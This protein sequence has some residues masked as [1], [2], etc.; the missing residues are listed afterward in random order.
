VLNLESDF[1]ANRNNSEMRDIRFELPIVLKSLETFWNYTDDNKDQLRNPVCHW[2]VQMGQIKPGSQSFF[3]GRFNNAITI[4][5][6]IV[7]T[8][9]VCIT[10][11]EQWNTYDW[12]KRFLAVCLLLNMTTVPLAIILKLTKGITAKPDILVK[13]AY[14]WLLLATLLFNR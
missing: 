14:I 3:E 7:V 5:L 13:T 11:A 1:G 6:A 4:L 2:G 9:A 10:V 12:I 8:L